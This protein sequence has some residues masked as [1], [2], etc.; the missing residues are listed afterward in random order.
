MLRARGVRR[1]NR[2]LDAVDD[3]HLPAEDGFH[4]FEQ[5]FDNVEDRRALLGLGN[6]TA[7]R[8]RMSRAVDGTL[9]VYDYL[10]FLTNHC[11]FYVVEI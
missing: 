3:F 2:D 5:R 11:I 7:S 8:D 1:E 9:P 6:I 4:V 10:P